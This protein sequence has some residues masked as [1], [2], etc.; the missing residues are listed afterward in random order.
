MTYNLIYSVPVKVHVNK[1]FIDISGVQLNEGATD[2]ESNTHLLLAGAIVSSTEVWKFPAALWIHLF[3]LT[4]VSLSSC[5]T[6]VDGAMLIHVKD[7][8]AFSQNRF[9]YHYVIPFNSKNNLALL[10][11]FLP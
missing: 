4:C 11:V 5:F 1:V 10:G 6:Y 8:Y 7:S 2:P 3:F 9:L